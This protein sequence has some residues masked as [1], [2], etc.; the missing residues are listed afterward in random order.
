MAITF[1]Q[2]TS[3]NHGSGTSGNM[4]FSSATIQGNLVLVFIQWSGSV[5]EITSVT[6]TAGNTYALI[7]EK[8]GATGWVTALFMGMQTTGGVTTITVNI[9]PSTFRFDWFLA[10]FSGISGPA[11]VNAFDTSATA[12]GA[13]STPSVS[14]TPA[15][16]GKLII[17]CI[18]TGANN[19]P[20]TAGSGYTIFDSAG[21]R[22]AN[23][24]YK[25]SGTTSET[26]SMSLDF[27][28]TWAIIAASFNQYTPPP[29]IG[30]INRTN[31][32]INRA[33]YY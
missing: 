33:S 24:E 11:N 28:V 17:G 20:A 29:P 7:A 27:S 3:P 8:A 13:S 25:L 5:G 10:E 18:G 12:N 4:S 14:L 16:A 26:V 31:Q 15:S 30:K 6:D 32:A 19:L 23:G 2:K 21:S 9:S 22:R 1:V